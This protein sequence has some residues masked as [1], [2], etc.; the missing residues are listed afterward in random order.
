VIERFKTEEHH[1]SWVET[2]EEFAVLI[3]QGL[4]HI[5]TSHPEAVDT[6]VDWALEGLDLEKA[7]LQPSTP[8]KVRHLK[9]G[10]NLTGALAVCDTSVALRLLNKGV[11]HKLIDLYQS[12]YMSVS[13]KLHIIR[14]LDQTTHF[15]EGL[16]AFL[17]RDQA[18]MTGVSGY[19]RLLEIML[20]KQDFR[21]MVAMSALIQ[22][23]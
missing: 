4:P 3:P 14:S 15:H 16:R 6:L 11:Q 5:V 7:M 9:M 18:H 13:V 22:K 10:V 19:Q 21:T 1:D 17:E 23:M 12:Q 8:F 20:S 2:L